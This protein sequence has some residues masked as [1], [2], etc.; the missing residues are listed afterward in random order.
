MANEYKSKL[1][2]WAN[3]IKGEGTFCFTD[4]TEVIFPRSSPECS[5]CDESIDAIRATLIDKF[6][7]VTEWD[8]DG[9]WVDDDGNEICEPVKLLV[10]AHNCID[11]PKD[12]SV[13]ANTIAYAM[14]HSGQKSVSVL[15]QNK[16]NILPRKGVLKKIW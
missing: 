16:F 5:N 3:E 10:S 4:K 13:I 9:C 14:E 7:G 1:Q 12:A 11:D 2:E 6:G 8:G 15:E